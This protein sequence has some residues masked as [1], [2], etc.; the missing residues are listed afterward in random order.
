MPKKDGSGN[1]NGEKKGMSWRELQKENA[2][3]LKRLRKRQR[4]VTVN[5]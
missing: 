3:R 1:I 2:K 5:N 4:S